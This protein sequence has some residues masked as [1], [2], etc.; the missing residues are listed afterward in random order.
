MNLVLARLR[1][2]VRGPSCSFRAQTAY[3]AF[4]LD[5]DPS[6]RGTRLGLRLLRRVP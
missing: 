4:Y 1:R 2:V 5:L 6:L 3:M